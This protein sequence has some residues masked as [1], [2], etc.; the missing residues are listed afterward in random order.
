[1]TA[2]DLDLATFGNGFGYGAPFFDQRFFWMVDTKDAERSQR[3]GRLYTFNAWRGAQLHSTQWT[4]PRAGERRRLSGREY[5]VYQSSRRWFR[6]M[7]SWRLVDLD[8][9]KTLDEEHALL[10]TV[11]K[12]LCR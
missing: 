12:E 6:V 10:A 7:V 11:E 2:F 1:L 4:H 3:N 5:V 9:C 8:R